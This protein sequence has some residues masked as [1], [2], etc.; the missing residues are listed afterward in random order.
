MP[1]PAGPPAPS[2]HPRRSRQSAQSIGVPRP[3]RARHLSTPSASRR[4]VSSRLARCARR[5]WR[6]EASR[7]R[8]RLLGNPGED[9]RG[10]RQRTSTSGPF[11]LAVEGRVSSARGGLATCSSARAKAGSHSPSCPSRRQACR[12]AL[13]PSGW[14]RRGCG[15]RQVAVLL[16]G[17]APA[18][19][20]RFAQVPAQS[21]CRCP[22]SRRGP[23][24]LEVSWRWAGVRSA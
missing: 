15:S 23:A 18:E 22:R 12:R 20:A 14:R 2:P 24:L 11:G 4:R 1:A 19:G 16:R 8:R 5:R 13:A 7:K 10:G 6:G 21:E 9:H 3:S 17:A